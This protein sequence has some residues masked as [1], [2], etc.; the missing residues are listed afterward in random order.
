MSIDKT[1][2]L[3]VVL[4]LVE[5]MVAVGLGVPLK[6]LTGVVTDIRLV[7]RAAVANYVLVPVITILLLDFFQAKP[8]VAV[9]PRSSVCF[10]A[11]G[12]FERE[13]PRRCWV[14]GRSGGIICITCAVAFESSDTAHG[15]GSGS[16]N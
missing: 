1:A 2:N 4:L 10:T 15:T 3:L 16:K 12:D 8:M 7:V 13:C 6:D 11:D 5:M 14:N 9:C